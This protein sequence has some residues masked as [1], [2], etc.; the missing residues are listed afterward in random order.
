[1]AAVPNAWS[2]SNTAAL[3][4]S[5]ARV[6]A[7]DSTLTSLFVLPNQSLPTAQWQALCQALKTNTQLRE[8]YASGHAIDEVGALILAEALMDNTALEKLCIGNSTFGD[9]GVAAVAPGLALNASIQQLDL[10]YK[11]V[12]HFGVKTLIEALQDPMSPCRLTHL[13][14]SRNVGIADAGAK[15]LAEGMRVG[16]AS[17]S[18]AEVVP[19]RKGEFPGLHHLQSLSLRECG[20][21]ASACIPVCGSLTELD[22]RG[23]C[24][25]S[26]TGDNGAFVAIVEAVAAGAPRLERLQ[27]CPLVA[28]SVAS[29]I[30]GCMR[31][32]LCE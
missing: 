15:L 5:I 2:R 23:N 27:V 31:M 12:S 4:A 19:E 18:G 14:L 11:G 32:R 10:E 29:Y 7:N 3:D 24:F 16:D 20:L 17:G 21:T 9:E 28:L 26:T 8:L 1:M 6:A 22:L 25:A 13:I 30:G